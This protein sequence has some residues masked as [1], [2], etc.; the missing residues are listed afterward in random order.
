MSLNRINYVDDIC[1]A[2]VTINDNI[3]KISK[4][5]NGHIDSYSIDVTDNETEQLHTYIE[6][7]EMS[8]GVLLIDIDNNPYKT[9]IEKLKK[10]GFSLQK[11]NNDEYGDYMLKNNNF[12]IYF[13][14]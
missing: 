7:I 6:D 5:D 4:Y 12:I 10:I 1:K 3:D 13:N 8:S 14:K 2:L 9:A 11:S